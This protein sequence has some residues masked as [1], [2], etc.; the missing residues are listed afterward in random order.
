MNEV[1]SFPATSSLKPLGRILKIDAPIYC[2]VCTK[3]CQSNFKLKEHLRVHT[4]ERPFQCDTCGLAFKLKH[5]LKRHVMTMHLG[6][7]QYTCHICGYICNL[8]YH[9]D[10]HYRIHTGV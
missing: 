2:S 6:R 1:I 9:L 7:S 4:G 5:Q 10:R 3:L 8:K